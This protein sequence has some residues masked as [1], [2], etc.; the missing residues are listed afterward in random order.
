MTPF[1]K[2]LALS[3]VISIAAQAGV[4]TKIT[5]AGA[6]GANDTAAWGTAAADFTS[7]ASPYGVT[8]GNGV[9]VSASLT[10]GFTIFVQNGVAYASNFFPG[11][12]VLATF[13]T[14]GTVRID[15]N[16]AISGVGFKIAHDNFGPFSGSISF[17]GTGNVLFSTINTY[18][19]TSSGASD[20]SAAFWAGIS[21]ATD[22]TRIDISVNPAGGT[23]GFA[24]GQL[25][26]LTST[27]VPEPSSIGLLSLGLA[28]C[29][30]LRRQRKQ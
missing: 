7:V 21:S 23:S 2:S 4:I 13:P 8:S 6:L 27:A 9:G 30:L 25:N 20:G 15:F 17:F 24:I 5:S 14:E 3:I 22:I 28:A 18:S 19:G 11:D 26:L 10:G 29:G 1:I 12:I 16:T